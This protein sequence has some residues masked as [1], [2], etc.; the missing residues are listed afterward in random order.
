MSGATII[1]TEF[2]SQ[3]SEWAKR[4]AI[5]NTMNFVRLADSADGKRVRVPLRGSK[6]RAASCREGLDSDF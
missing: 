6:L 5:A 3:E 1:E 2:R 4:P